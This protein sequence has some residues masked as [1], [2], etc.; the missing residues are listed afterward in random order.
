M[1]LRF[2]E[3]ANS[4]APEAPLATM[5]RTQWFRFVAAA[6]FTTCLATVVPFWMALLWIGAVTAIGLVRSAAERREQ[7]DARTT[8]GK[9]RSARFMAIVVINEAIWAVAPVLAWNGDSAFAI[10]MGFVLLHILW[11]VGIGHFQI[12]PRLALIATSPFALVAAWFLTRLWSGPMFLPALACEGV[13]CL[14]ITGRMLRGWMTQ[15]TLNQIDDRQAQLIENLEEERDHARAGERAKAS[16]VAMISHELRTPMNGVIGAGQLLAGTRLDATQQDYVGVIT[17]SA[18]SLLVLLNDIIDLTQAKSGR[19]KLEPETVDLRELIGRSARVWESGARARGLT[20]SV[21]IDASTPQRIVADPARVCQVVQNLLSN[22]VKFTEAG[23]VTLRVAPDPAGGRLCITVAD[24]GLGVP[25]AHRESIFQSFAQIDASVTR[26]FGG[27]GLGLPISRKLARLMGGDLACAPAA[28]GGSVFVFEFPCDAA[29]PEAAL[30]ETAETPDS[31]SEAQ[32]LRVLIVEDH[33]VN[34]MILER[35]LQSAGH[36]TASAE[37]GAI[38]LEILAVERF[39]LALMDVNMPVMDG[40]TATRALREFDGPARDM[41]VAIVSAAIRPE[42]H[43]AGFEAG[44]DAYLEKPVDFAV[45]SQL[46]DRVGSA[47]PVVH[48][49]VA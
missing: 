23:A 47:G 25:E 40:L 28:N 24:T 9:R 7:T 49:A 20:F 38:A 11:G 14:H 21:E 8:R 45:L 17:R 33:P 13:W 37:N 39:D 15:Q 10:P 26:R 44:A 18:Q 46:L 30:A 1:T 41:P 4:G 22:A 19:L 16:F 32:P 36:R 27:A 5:V 31:I 6:G 29:E 12:W 2:R 42:D 3:N 35:F 48:A 43:K 34:R